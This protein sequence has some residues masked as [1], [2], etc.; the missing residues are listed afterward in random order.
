[1][2]WFFIIGGV[3]GGENAMFPSNA[4]AQMEIVGDVIVSL[5]FCSLL[6]A[7]RVISTW[8]WLRPLDEC[9]CFAKR[10]II[11]SLADLC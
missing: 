2:F 7:I 6:E 11:F 10:C 8:C 9:Y 1:M 4:F 3:G 5:F